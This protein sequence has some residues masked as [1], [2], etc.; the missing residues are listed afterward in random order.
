MMTRIV[1][2][3]FAGSA[4]LIMPQTLSGQDVQEVQRLKQQIEPSSMADALEG[5]S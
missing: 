2:L 4:M 3:A 5:A 1:V